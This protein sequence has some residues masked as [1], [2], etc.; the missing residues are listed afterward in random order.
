MTIRKIVRVLFIIFGLVEIFVYFRSGF[1]SYPD[2]FMGGMFIFMSAT[3]F[4][5]QCPLIS[6]VTRMF[7][8]QK[9]KK[10]VT[11]KI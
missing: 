6:A 3:N 4:C 2:L 11:E 9:H 8:R 10:I 1:E 5:T 7:R